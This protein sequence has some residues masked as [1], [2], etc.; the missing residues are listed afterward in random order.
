MKELDLIRKGYS[1]ANH[2]KC[3]FEAFWWLKKA[4]VLSLGCEVDSKKASELRIKEWR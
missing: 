1:G 2:K 3:L 4:H